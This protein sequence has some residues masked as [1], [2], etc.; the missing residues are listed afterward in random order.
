[1][2]ER[3]RRSTARPDYKKLSDV[4]LPRAKRSDCGSKSKLY[5]VSVVERQ[6]EHR[7]VKIHYMGYGVQHDEWRDEEEIIVL[8]DPSPRPFSLY[9]EL[10]DR[11]KQGL[12]SGRKVSPIVRVDMIFDKVQFDGGLKQCGV[13]VRTLHGTERYRINHYRDLNSLLGR[14]WHIRGLNS[15][16]DYCYVVL[17]TVEFYL[18][19]RQPLQEFFPAQG[20]P[21]CNPRD[22][23]YM[24]TF[25]FVRGDGTPSDFGKNKEI[26]FE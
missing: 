4:V 26:F 17:E 3:P 23:G 25:S 8:E 19:K 13:L 5:A 18:H 10:G 14:N 11:I 1:M 12:N 20:K 22:L 9:M 16:G 2:M 6:P 7:R 21:L 15:N 24:L